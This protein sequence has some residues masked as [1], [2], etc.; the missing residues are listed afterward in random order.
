M[1]IARR[2]NRKKRRWSLALGRWPNP[3]VDGAMRVLDR[4]PS[5]GGT[6]GAQDRGVRQRPKTND[7][8]LSGYVCV[9]NAAA[10]LGP[11]IGASAVVAAAGAAAYHSM[12][13]WA[14]GF[15][16]SFVAGTPASK[17][18]ALTYD[19]GPNDPHTLQL[20]DVLAKDGV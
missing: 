19:D 2:V 12:A 20:L 6:H 1:T 11:I 15:G 7:Q 10:M 5:R 3:I 9:Y 8:R 16:A 18:I 17:Q 13:P 4:R 14:Q